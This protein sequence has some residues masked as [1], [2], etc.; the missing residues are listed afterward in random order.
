MAK[1]T[2]INFISKKPF[3]SENIDLLPCGE[4]MRVT[5]RVTKVTKMISGKL[6]SSIVEQGTEGSSASHTQNKVILTNSNNLTKELENVSVA[7]NNG[8]FLTL[9]D[10]AKGTTTWLPARTIKEV[11]IL[12]K[13]SDHRSSDKANIH[14]YDHTKRPVVDAWVNPTGAFVYISRP[15]QGLENWINADQ[16]AEIEFLS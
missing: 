14:F 9:K 8:G 7:S 1:I 5:D 13:C 15:S 10:D 12:S 16:I 2:T 3:K 6:F 4:F 11:E